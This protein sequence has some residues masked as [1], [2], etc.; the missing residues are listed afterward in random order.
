MTVIENRAIKTLLQLMLDNQ[1]LFKSGLCN[2][3]DKLPINYEEWRTLK[4]YIKENR[5]SMFSSTNAFLHCTD[6][7]YWKIGDIKPRLKWINKHIQK[8]IN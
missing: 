1:D 5:P 6:C 7:Y 2:W 4:K 3:S 8:Q